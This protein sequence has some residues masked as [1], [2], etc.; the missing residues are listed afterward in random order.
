VDCQVARAA[1]S[2]AEAVDGRAG[3]RALNAVNAA[4][5][6]I[7]E[8]ELTA[9][10]QDAATRNVLDMAKR[11]G[12]SAWLLAPDSR[13]DAHEFAVGVRYRLGITI[14]PATGYCKGCGVSLP[15]R[16]LMYHAPG[17]V[18]LP[19]IN[20]TYPHD[21]VKHTLAKLCRELLIDQ[22]EEPR[23]LAVDV[24]GVQ[25]RPDIR[26]WIGGHVSGH[27]GGH[28][29][30]RAD[31]ERTRADN[32]RTRADNGR[33]NADPSGPHTDMSGHEGGLAGGHERTRLDV[34]S[35]STVAQ[36]T[37]SV[38]VDVTAVNAAA[39]SLAHRTVKSYSFCTLLST[40]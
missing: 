14:G 9:L 19:G 33:T 24:D 8:A 31:N 15:A 27:T 22:E 3:P 28:E 4:A 7:A 17:C 26:I 20:A 39:P 21:R 40:P 37:S 35:S 16:D 13:L 34:A 29:R 10:Q 1:T 5:T 30:T 18:R 23:D 38:A 32:E 2:F 25:K 6:V 36:C 11:A 12:A